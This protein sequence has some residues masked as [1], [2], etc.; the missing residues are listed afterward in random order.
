MEYLSRIHPRDDPHVEVTL[1]G[2]VQGHETA[3]K[4][5]AVGFGEIEVHFEHFMKNHI[6]CGDVWWIWNWVAMDSTTFFVPVASDG[7]LVRRPRCGTHQ[8]MRKAAELFSG[9][10]G[11]SVAST[12]MG[13]ETTICIEAN[14]D[15]AE[16]AASAHRLPV[17]KIDEVW[18]QFISNGTVDEPA[19]WVADVRD[20]RVKFLLSILEVRHAWASPP[21]P[22][23]CGMASLHGLSC[24]DGMLFAQTIRIARDVGL[25]SLALE[26]ARSLKYHHHFRHVQNFAEELGFQSCT[27]FSRQLYRSSPAESM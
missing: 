13:L 16:A 8:P 23:W 1:V 15:V 21:C 22:P 19:I 17:K 3:W 10:M 12:L 11:W 25:V 2:L 20:Q 26:N 14:P 9:F 4:A 5:C 18:S 24:D 27:E 6:A 7:R